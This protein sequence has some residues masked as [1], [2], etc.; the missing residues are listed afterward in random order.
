[1]GRDG[2]TLESFVGEGSCGFY[3]APVAIILSIDRAFTKD[4]YLCLG[5]FLGYLVLAAHDLGLATCPVGLIAA[6]GDEI[7]D[8]LNIPETKEVM[9]GVALGYPDD[10]SPLA[11]FATPR[12]SPESYVRWFT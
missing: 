11:S 5:A 10:T 7:G 4:R 6:Y 9:I 1:V 3:K 2:I 12:V 8:Q